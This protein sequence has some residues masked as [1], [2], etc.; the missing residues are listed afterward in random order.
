MSRGEGWRNTYHLVAVEYSINSS[1]K[2]IEWFLD[3][4]EIMK[5][6]VIV[7]FRQYWLMSEPSHF[8]DNNTSDNICYY[9]LK[10]QY[11]PNNIRVCI[12]L[13]SVKSIIICQ[14]KRYRKYISII[15]YREKYSEMTFTT[16]F[17]GIHWNIW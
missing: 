3:I 17:P 4:N 16:V 10:Y 12:S 11:I 9:K 7:S 13:K 8:I 5:P 6:K 1:L 15:A 2:A 14:R